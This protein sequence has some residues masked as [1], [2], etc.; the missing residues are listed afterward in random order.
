[1]NRHFM[2]VELLECSCTACWEANKIRSVY[3]PFLPR[4]AR[5]T[6]LA[7]L[8]T[9]IGTECLEQTAND[10]RGFSKSIRNF[11]GGDLYAYDEGFLSTQVRSKGGQL[12]VKPFIVELGI[13]VLNHKV[14]RISN[15]PNASKIGLSFSFNPSNAT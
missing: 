10:Y 8:Q 13:V 14:K 7:K 5:W 15:R 1:M 9:N 2:T 11:R 4:F 3:T 6:L 12:A